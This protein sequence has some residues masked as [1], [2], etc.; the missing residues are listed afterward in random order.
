MR[1][2]NLQYAGSESICKMKLIITNP[3]STTPALTK[4]N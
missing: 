2:E 3:Q 1:K 4:A